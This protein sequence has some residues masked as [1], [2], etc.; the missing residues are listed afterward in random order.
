MP[1][2][3]NAAN[4]IAVDAFLHERCGFND[5]ARVVEACMDAHDVQPVSSIDQLADVDAWSRQRARA[6]LSKLTV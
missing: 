6:V 5:I 4:E 2:V 1:C 3:M